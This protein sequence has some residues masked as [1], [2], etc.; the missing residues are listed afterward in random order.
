[1]AL[2]ENYVEIGNPTIDNDFILSHSDYENYLDFSDYG[3]FDTSKSY[4]IVFRFKSDSSYPYCGILSLADGTISISFQMN[5]LYI[6]FFGRSFQLSKVYPSE[7]TYYKFSYLP[8]LPY[9]H[10][11]TSTDGI[12]WTKRDQFNIPVYQFENSIHTIGNA[13]GMGIESENTYLDLKN[14]YITVDGQDWFKAVENKYYPPIVT[15]TDVFSLNKTF[16]GKKQINSIDCNNVQFVDDE[17]FITSLPEFSRFLPIFINI[18]P[19]INLLNKK[20]Q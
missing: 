15:A 14:L 12:E 5:K 20:L 16:R 6:V 7:W 18:P 8:E 3:T 17:K 11:F 2:S 4:D 10:Y 19:K 13:R 1:M 9:F